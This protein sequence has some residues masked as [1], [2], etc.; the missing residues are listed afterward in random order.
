MQH[1]K[2]KKKGSVN[3][4]FHTSKLSLFPLKLAKNVNK[5]DIKI[6]KQI[7][8]MVGFTCEIRSIPSKYVYIKRT[9]QGNV[10]FAMLFS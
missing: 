10:V 9:Y 6:S 8:V 4:T 3:E 1:Q 7:S 5:S 2:I